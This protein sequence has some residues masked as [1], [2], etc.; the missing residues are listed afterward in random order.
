MIGDQG[1]LKKEMVCCCLGSVFGIASSHT[2][3]PTVARSECVGARAVPRGTRHLRPRADAAASYPFAVG[4]TIFFLSMCYIDS[5]EEGVD[6]RLTSVLSGKVSLF[7]F[8]YN[9][10]L[11]RCTCSSSRACATWSLFCSDVFSSVK[12]KLLFKASSRESA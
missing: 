1:L 9:K 4:N 12:R 8:K 5:S 6:S 11:F 2:C 7:S 10:H 3:Y